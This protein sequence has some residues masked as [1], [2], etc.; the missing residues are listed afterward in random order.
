[1]ERALRV[2]TSSAARARARAV[3]RALH[4]ENGTDVALDALETSLAKRVRGHAAARGASE[5]SLLTVRVKTQTTTVT[6]ISCEF[7]SQFDS[8]PRTHL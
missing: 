8:L 7:C 6:F 5:A 2:A 4:A 3:S 1:M